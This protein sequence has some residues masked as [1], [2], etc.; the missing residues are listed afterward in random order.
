MDN[1]Q[2]S[3]LDAPVQKIQD[4]IDQVFNPPPVVGVLRLAGVIGQLGHVRRGL[5]LASM[6]G[7]IERVFKLKNLKA[8]ALAIN[9]P[10]GSP[11]QAALIAKRIRAMAEEKEIPVIAFTEDVAASGGYWLACV[12]D[13]IFAD[14]NSIIGSIGVISAGFGFTDLLKQYGIERR[15]HAMG[16]RKGMLDPFQ[17][18]KAEDVE[19]L[20]SIQRDIYESFQRLV[21][22]RRHGKLKAEEDELFSGA[23]WTGT[24]ALEM[25]LIDGI[26]DMRSVMRDRFGEK[27]R[28]RLVAPHQSWWQRHLKLPGSGPVG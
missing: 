17:K 16:E 2:H 26:G 21:T 23:F 18:E 1:K 6:A 8:V 28:L 12:A 4:L 3:A 19:H 24:R 7:P 25:G 27:V 10:G 20:K 11:V 5:D 13:E 15:M 14:E 9:S 22:E